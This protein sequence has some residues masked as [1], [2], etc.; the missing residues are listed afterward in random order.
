MIVKDSQS[1]L[2]EALV[3][4]IELRLRNRLSDFECKPIGLATGRTMRSI[5]SSLVDRLKQWPSD[6][7]ER[8][9]KGWF[10]FN[11][12]E[13]IG[14]GIDD[15][16]SFISYMARYL[17]EPLQLSSEQ[18]L[19]PNGRAKNPHSEA[20]AYREKLVCFG[21]IGVQL[22]GLGVNGHIGFNEPPCGAKSLCRVVSL[23]PSTIKQNAVEFACQEDQVPSRAITLGVEEILQAED[24]HLVVTG[25]EKA[26]ILF[27][28][29]NSSLSE[30]LPASWLR[31]HPNVYI[32]ADKA[33]IRINK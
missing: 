12:D 15:A 19:I 27:K 4:E 13:Y 18:L 28:L 33:A 29:L 21:G 14:L 10:S 26:N 30:D 1:T 25:S 16:Q 31:L 3:D 5:Y 2:A 9:R 8:L 11:L 23:S 32:W 7:L 6:E 22:L 20:L 17:G 24:I